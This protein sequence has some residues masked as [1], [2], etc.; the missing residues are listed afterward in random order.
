MFYMF[1]SY[2]TAVDFTTQL[3]QCTEIAGV[4]IKK[5]KKTHLCE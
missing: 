3:A 4:K 2:F 1:G 5:K